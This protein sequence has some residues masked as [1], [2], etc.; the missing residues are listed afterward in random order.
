MSCLL[1]SRSQPQE[2]LFTALRSE[3]AR[4]QFWTESGGTSY[5]KLDLEQIRNVFLPSDSASRL[6][7]AAAA[8]KWMATVEAMHE[9][10]VEVGRENDR[11][12]IL[13]SPLIG[14]IEAEEDE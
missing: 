4:I 5:G 7:D 9:S 11:R 1:R 14:L 6:V 2:W 3:G 12:P 10:W 13:N 8:R